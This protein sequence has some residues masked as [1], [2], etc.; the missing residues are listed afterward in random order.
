MGIETLRK[1]PSEGE[2]KLYAEISSI[3]IDSGLR[4]RSRNESTQT[5]GCKTPDSNKENDKLNSISNKSDIC[6][7]SL[8][9]GNGEMASNRENFKIEI[10]YP[11]IDYIYIYKAF[12]SVLNI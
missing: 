7:K 2:K 11:S 8:L 4:E 12:S 10:N 1:E 9:T 6:G 3:S 5:C